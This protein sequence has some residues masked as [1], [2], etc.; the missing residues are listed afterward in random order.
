MLLNINFDTH[1]Y[2]IKNDKNQL[3]CMH[4]HFLFANSMKNMLHIRLSISIHS[5]CSNL[6]TQLQNPYGFPSSVPVR[7]FSFLSLIPCTF[8]IAAIYN[9]MQLAPISQYVE[10]FFTLFG[11]FRFVC[12]A[13]PFVV[14]E[15]TALPMDLFFL[16]CFVSVLTFNVIR[17]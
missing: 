4:A 6:Q 11:D 17:D 5:D 3:F 15:S 16:L 7:Y 2:E 12:T 10:P 14:Y 9:Q 1:S 13:L 8:E